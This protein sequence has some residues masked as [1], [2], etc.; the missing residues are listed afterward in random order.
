MKEGRKKEGGKE[1]QIQAGRYCTHKIR[2]PLTQIRPILLRRTS[3][4]NPSQPQILPVIDSHM[5]Y[6]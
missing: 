2:L 1:K 3:T 4:R 6:I 5:T